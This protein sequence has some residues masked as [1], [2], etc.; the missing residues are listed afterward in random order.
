MSFCIF[1]RNFSLFFVLLFCLFV[2][3]ERK[4]ID[5][6][7]ECILYVNEDLSGPFHTTMYNSLCVCSLC[8]CTTCI[9]RFVEIKLI[10]YI[11]WHDPFFLNKE[12]KY[13]QYQL[14]IYDYD[15]RSFNNSK[16]I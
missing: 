7:V 10:I 12:F 3:F 13:T 14:Q 6:D 16:H 15:I 2:F 1:C 8:I 9:Y 11:N 5:F 4:G